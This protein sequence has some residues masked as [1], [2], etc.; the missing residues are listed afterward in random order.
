[1]STTSTEYNTKIPQ[2]EGNG[3]NGTAALHQPGWPVT[4]FKYDLGDNPLWQEFLDQLE[5]NR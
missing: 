5:A 2:A 3:A 4:E 1:M